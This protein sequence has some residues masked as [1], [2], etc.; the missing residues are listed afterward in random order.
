MLEIRRPT[1][2][3][4]LALKPAFLGEL[5]EQAYLL[6]LDLQTEVLELAEQVLPCPLGALAPDAPGPD[7]GQVLHVRPGPA[8][9]SRLKWLRNISSGE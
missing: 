3:L 2:P 1:E 5:P 8:I 4:L 7:D 9:L 6:L